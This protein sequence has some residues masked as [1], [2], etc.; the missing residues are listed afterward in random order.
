M[1]F[2][3]ISNDHMNKGD[4]AFDQA[5]AFLELN[6]LK[7]G[8][9]PYA[10]MVGYIG[11]RKGNKAAAAKTFLDKWIKQV[12]PEEWSTKIMRY[13]HGDLTDAGLLAL[14]VDNDELT[15]AHAYVGEMQLLGGMPDLAKVHFNWVKDS[16]NKTFTEY[17]FAIAEL[18]R[19]AEPATKRPIVPKQR[20]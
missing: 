17:D 19:M 5:S 9:A 8:S 14:A 1:P 3:T 6:G 12:E 13:M 18:N 10:I 2:S 4:S 11:L 16:G 7:G 20:N 15:E